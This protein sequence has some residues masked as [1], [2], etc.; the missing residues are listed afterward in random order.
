M[1]PDELTADEL[2][3]RMHKLID[4]KIEA[5]LAFYD[6]KLAEFFR[7]HFPEKF[8]CDPV[9]F[10]PKNEASVIV[11]KWIRDQRME[12]ALKNMAAERR[13][14]AAGYKVIKPDLP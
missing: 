14:T 11:S 13:L 6:E 5:Q 4:S 12:E 3:A 2:Q 7:E 10:V 1:E 9:T 8:G